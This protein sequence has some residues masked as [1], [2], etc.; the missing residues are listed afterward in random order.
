ML[1]LSVIVALAQV[2]IALQTSQPP[3][4]SPPPLT[5]SVSGVVVTDAGDELRPVRVI[6]RGE[7]ESGVTATTWSSD[8]EG[9]FTIPNLPAGSYRVFLEATPFV[10]RKG[11]PVRH[12][13]GVPVRVTGDVLDLVVVA[14]PGITL[15][16]SLVFPAGAPP[17]P[18]RN[19]W[20]VAAWIDDRPSARAMVDDDGRFSLGD[21][22]GLVRIGLS[23]PPAGYTLRTVR[24][25]EADITGEF[26]EMSAGEDRELRLELVPA[27]SLAGEGCIFTSLTALR[28]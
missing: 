19:L 26:V 1:T 13:A 15:S 24:L 20:V 27:R 11:R 4:G 10:T 17:A 6:A 12:F 7:G 8:R 21:V 5:F 2:G 18:L 16:G 28:P 22:F 23:K 25:G 9:R 14:R 3:A